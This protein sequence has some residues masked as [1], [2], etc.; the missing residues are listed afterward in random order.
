M[1]IAWV[2]THGSLVGGAEHYIKRT[3]EHLRERGVRSTLLYDP[4]FSTSHAMLDAFDA[5]FPLVD[6]VAQ[7]RDAKV[8]LVYVHQTRRPEIADALAHSPVPVIE[9]FHDHWLFCL[10]VQKYTTIQRQTCT[11][12]VSAAACYPCMG[13]VHRNAGFP[14]FKLRTIS[15]LQGEHQARRHFAGFVTGSS[16]MAE[17]AIAHGFDPTKVHVAPLYAEPPVHYEDRVER[18]T[19]RLLY[20]GAIL[21]Y[22]GLDVLIEALSH[23]VHKVRLDVIGD[24]SFMSDMR[25]LVHKLGLESRV[26]FLGKKGREEIDRHYRRAT[27]LVVPSRTPESFGIV[28]AEAMSYGQP[29]IVSDIGGVLE[30]LE[31][32]RT[33]LTFPI[34]DA[35]GL[36]NAIDLMV[37]N[38]AL[39]RNMGIA[40]QRR[41]DQRFRPE[42]HMDRLLAIFTGI[43]QRV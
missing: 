24:G 20:V 12:V 18:D 35:R 8:D 9:F 39:A 4:N 36:A 19:D 43:L 3:T 38:P 33:G 31:P 13:F 22:K 26:S 14:G 30:W 1:H 21:R 5:A 34:N 27:C 29:A 11:Q 37:G 42:H 25:A 28:G 10:R 23:T 41:Y 6:V 2:N 15:D 32:G 16:Y 17:Q 7:V 40:A